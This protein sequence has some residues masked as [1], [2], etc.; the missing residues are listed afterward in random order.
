MLSLE[1]DEAVITALYLIGQENQS[2]GQAGQDFAPASSKASYHLPLGTMLLHDARKW[3]ELS[4]LYLT[5]LS[6]SPSHNPSL[7]PSPDDTARSDQQPL[8]LHEKK[9]L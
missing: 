5:S 2:Q 3:L 9:K 1:K 8:L 4:C 7:S 6:P